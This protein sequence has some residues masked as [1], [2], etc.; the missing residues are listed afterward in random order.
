LVVRTS[1]FCGPWDQHKFVTQAL[2]IISGGNNFL[3]SNDHVIS[4]T[5]VPDLVNA[6]LDL[7][8][9]GETG[10]WHLSNPSEITWSEFAI[11][12]AKKCGLDFSL[13]KPTPSSKLGYI[14]ERPLYSA[15]GSERG[16]LLPQLDNAI[17]RYLQEVDLNVNMQ[18]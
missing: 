4:P 16:I 17:N 12:V 10:I 13:V 1:S 3:A 11:S 7:L 14:A 18:H 6:S 8:I 5:Y 2:K 9:D 15:L